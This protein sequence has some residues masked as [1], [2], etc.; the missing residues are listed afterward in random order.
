[1]NVA[2]RAFPGGVQPPQHKEPSRRSPIQPAPL[3]Q[4]LI[5]P[6]QQHIGTAAIPIVKTGERVLK[7]QMIAKATGYV[8]V[9]LHAPSSGT[10]ID[11]ADYP[12]PHPSGLNGPCLVIE[13]DGEDRWLDLTPQT[14]YQRL[15]P[16]H[17]RNLVRDAGIVG[18]GGAGFPTFI[19]LNPGPNNIIDTLII[20][21]IECEPYITC[22]D[23]LM[24]ERAAEIVRGANIIRY[25]LQAKTCIIAIEDNKPEAYAAMQQAAQG[26]D[27]QVLLLPTLYPQGSEKQLIQV[28]T[29]KEVPHNGLPSHIGVVMQ[30]VATAAAIYRAIE[31]G[32][33]LISRIVTVTGNAVARPGN[34]DVLL[35]TPVN[36]LLTPVAPTTTI[37]R[38]LMGGPMMGFTLHS[39]QVPVIKTMNCLLAMGREEVPAPVPVL[40]CIRCGACAQVCPVSL[41]PQQL[42]WFSRSKEFA[43]AQEH[44]L[45]DCIECGCCAYVCPSNIP[46]VH[47]YRHA[48]A[49][50][51]AKEREKQK[52]DLARQRYDWRMARLEREKAEKE[53]RHKQK[54]MELQEP[55][56]FAGQSEDAK[57]AAILAAI[58]RAKAKKANITPAAAPSTANDKN[59]N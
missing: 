37:E 58:E 24:Q 40:P 53:A 51:G 21:G 15:D 33:P 11:I 6:L 12:V 27:M 17:L 5:L 7:G 38:L 10:V 50:I 36:E 19:K 54:K 59:N 43:K 26:H 39:Y 2:L 34:Y 35:G 28:I 23:L 42:Y 8:S 18:L 52:A 13:T 45:F 46:L 48:K 3:P 41:L 14:D 44:N 47:Y 9:A 25:A 56:P 55:A 31:K 32:E 22:D 30:N 4:R 20:N 29:G 16:S 1:M 57:K 49:E